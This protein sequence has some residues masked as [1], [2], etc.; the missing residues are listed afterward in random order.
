MVED[1]VCV[2]EEFYMY[3]AE[4]SVKWFALLSVKECVSR[5]FEMGEIDQ[6]LQV[7]A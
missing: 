1:V 5:L 3:D 7:S 6:C 4:G 2:G